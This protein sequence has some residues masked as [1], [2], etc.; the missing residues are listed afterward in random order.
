MSCLTGSLCFLTV[1]PGYLLKSPEYTKWEKGIFSH[2]YMSKTCKVFHKMK[3][4]YFVVQL[5]HSSKF[6][7]FPAVEMPLL[8]LREGC[9][10]IQGS[11]V[12]SSFS[13]VPVNS[14][15]ANHVIIKICTD[16][17]RRTDSSYKWATKM[18]QTKPIHQW[19]YALTHL[20]SSCCL[21]GLQPIFLTCKLISERFSE[22]LW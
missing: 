1:W 15:N 5:T 3:K 7:K 19:M 8:F 14:S 4:R 13:L 12:T 16:R 17:I 6:Q 11:L 21:M 20:F 2:S 9:N 18:A 22:R 10:I